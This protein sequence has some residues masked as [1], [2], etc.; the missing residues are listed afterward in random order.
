MKRYL[1]SDSDAKNSKMVESDIGNW[2]T[3]AEADARIQELEAQV[4]TLREALEPF[5][6]LAQ[7]L[8]DTRDPAVDIICDA[9][10]ASGLR[11]A[12]GL[13]PLD[14]HAARQALKNTEAE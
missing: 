11:D 7:R 2:V 10:L 6:K 9:R 8:W 3:R 13:R 1:L 14:L 12:V 4:A 5:D